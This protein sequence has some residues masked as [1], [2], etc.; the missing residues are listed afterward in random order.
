MAGRM[1]RAFAGFMAV[2]QLGLLLP[3]VTP[4]WGAADAESG[5]LRLVVYRPGT[6]WLDGV[7][8][9]DLTGAG[10]PPPRP[11]DGAV[12]QAT[13]IPAGAH[14]LQLKS[15]DAMWVEPEDEQAFTVAAGDTVTV[16]LGRPR[17]ITSPP[18]AG[19]RLGARELGPSPVWLDPGR[20]PGG[21]LVI[22][23][24]GYR[25][26]TLAADTLLARTRLSGALRIELVPL[27][28][29]LAMARA[30]PTPRRYLGLSRW[31]AFGV[32]TALLAGGVLGAARLKSLADDRFDIY[33]RTGDPARQ[34]DAFQ[35]AQRYDRLSLIGWGV[36][37]LAFLSAL[38]LVIQ[39]PPRGFVPT[40]A[41]GTDAAGEPAWQVGVSHAF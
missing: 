12:L 41:A 8:V 23:R 30:L 27:P 3:P 33:R 34:R 9:L 24:A 6:V 7:P 15:A 10:Q 31:A 2:L 19:V 32:S 40:V 4:V 20:L 28:G 37:E 1:R 35:A 11:W 13:E 5:L 22:E 39:E 29:T 38:Y 25:P 21:R 17:L 26:D 36:A 14:R 18:G 16:A